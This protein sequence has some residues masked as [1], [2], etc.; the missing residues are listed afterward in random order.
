MRVSYCCAI[1]LL[2]I[3]AAHAGGFIGRHDLAGDRV[4]AASLA[5]A[6]AQAA[7][8]A[9]RDGLAIRFPEDDP[10]GASAAWTSRSTAPLALTPNPDSDGAVAGQFLGGQCS[11]ALV[12]GACSQAATS[13]GRKTTI[14][15]AAPAVER[16][17]RPSRPRHARIVRAAVVPAP[18]A[19]KPV[20][21]GVPAPT[22][23][24]SPPPGARIAQVTGEFGQTPVQQAPPLKRVATR[25]QAPKPVASPPAAAP[26]PRIISSVGPRQIRPGQKQ[27]G[28]AGR[29]STSQDLQAFS[30]PG[31]LLSRP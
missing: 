16:P 31:S 30:Q 14:R 29:D 4:N 5:L 28:A 3:G 9:A 19:T 1:S 26:A 24:V 17:L 20:T 13:H 27:A 12:F 2:A 7:G 18:K 22:R 8:P 10:A 21:P 25:R 6:P 15:E 23:A 11:G